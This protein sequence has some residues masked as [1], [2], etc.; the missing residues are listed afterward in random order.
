MAAEAN[1]LRRIEKHLDALGDECWWLKVHGDQYTTKGTPD[2]VGSFRGQS[3]GFE[4]KAP[5]EKPTKIQLYQLARMEKSGAITAVFDNF[6]SFLLFWREKLDNL[7]YRKGI[8]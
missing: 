1:L 2:I 5:G 8:L 3:F 6:Q 7:P 4:L